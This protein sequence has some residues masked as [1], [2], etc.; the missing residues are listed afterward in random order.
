MQ[1]KLKFYEIGV[2]HVKRIVCIQGYDTESYGSFLLTM[3]KRTGNEFRLETQA[4]RTGREAE[5]KMRRLEI[6]ARWIRR[7][8]TKEAKHRPG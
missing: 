6:K 1:H 8:K 2:R 4:D 5:W 7:S 3:Q